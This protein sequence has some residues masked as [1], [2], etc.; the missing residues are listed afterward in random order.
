VDGIS[1]VIPKTDVLRTKTG[2]LFGIAVSF[3]VPAD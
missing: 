3:D 1:Y 2:P